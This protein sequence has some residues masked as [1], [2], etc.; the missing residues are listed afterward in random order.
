M[1]N[2]ITDTELKKEYYQKERQKSLVIPIGN[3]LYLFVSMKG[4]CTF[5]FKIYIKGITKSWM[6]LG[7]YPLMTVKQAQKKA[8]ECQEIVNSGQNPAE[9]QKEE[10]AKNITFTELTQIF[11]ERKLNEIR[12]EGISRKSKILQL[13]FLQNTLGNVRINE[14][15][16][17]DI[18]TKVLKPSVDKN[19]KAMADV[20]RKNIKQ[21]L[22]F[23]VKLE[24]IQKNP[25]SLLDNFKLTPRKRTFSI[26]ELKIF[27]NE[28]YIADIKTSQK[29]A[30]HLL[31][32]LGMRKS[33][34]CEAKWDQVDFENATFLNHQEKTGSP[35]TIYLPKQAVQ[36]LKKL[37]QAS[38]NEFI[39]NS[40]HSLN[41]MV[42]PTYLNAILYAKLLPYLKIKYNMPHFTIHDFRRTF[43]TVLN[44]QHQFDNLVISRAMGHQINGVE[45]H[46]NHA[47]YK[48]ALT[49]LWQFYADFIDSLIDP[50]LNIYELICV[51]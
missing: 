5:S 34:L 39:I 29:Y 33:E 10:N 20:H 8:I 9:K 45:R 47:G 22:D 19:K 40:T 44:D 27:L 51:E 48:E 35:Y 36:I 23:G 13:Q 4:K 7:E 12:K 37:K 14:L 11:I 17:H 43:S 46:Y 30:F 1:K 16:Q 41:S 18:Y 42:T 6:K 38:R 50:A 28:L 31:I 21:V 2:K 32:I 24:L 15:T 26:D 3:N 49:Q 25:A